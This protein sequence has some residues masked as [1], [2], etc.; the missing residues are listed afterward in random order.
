[1]ECELP[2]FYSYNE[3]IARKAHVCCECSAPILRGEQHFSCTGKWGGEL[4]SWHQHLLC[5]EACMFI[6]DK[7]NGGDCICFGG[8]FEWFDEAQWQCDKAHPI[9]R[10]LRSK[11][12][13]I[14]RRERDAN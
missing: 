14:R 13:S 8:L 9:W 11:L 4:S 7:L 6:R 1:M 3:P 12:A 10:E 2:E 5:M